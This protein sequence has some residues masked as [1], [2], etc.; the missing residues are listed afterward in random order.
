MMSQSSPQRLRR[1]FRKVDFEATS[2]INPLKVPEIAEA[3]VPNLLSSDAM[4]PGLTGI[5]FAIQLFTM[6]QATLDDG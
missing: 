2:L 6:K 5:R 1:P 4:M 3:G